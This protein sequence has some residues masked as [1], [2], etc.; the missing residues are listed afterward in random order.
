MKHLR[1][2][3]VLVLLA[4]QGLADTV[5]PTRTI[6][7]NARIDVTDLM[8][9]PATVAGAYSDI[10]EVLGMEARVALYPGRPIRP[11]DIGPPAIVD[12]NQIITLVYQTSGLLIAAEGRSLDRAG[13]GDRIRVMN[14]TSRSTLSGVVQSDGSVIVSP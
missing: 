11:G 14:L 9:R 10:D 3:L 2:S 5:V 12:R 1:L 4:S 13:A 7:A 8:L 6:R